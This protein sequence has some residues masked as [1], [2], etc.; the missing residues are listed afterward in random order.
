MVEVLLP[1]IPDLHMVSAPFALCDTLAAFVGE[2]SDATAV[3]VAAV[4]VMVAAA[5]AIV[6]G[7]LKK[8]SVQKRNNHLMTLHMR[9]METSY[10]S[11]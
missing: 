8:G 7:Q 4:A 1:G 6:V 3:A 2:V 10:L 11:S 5:A 9:G